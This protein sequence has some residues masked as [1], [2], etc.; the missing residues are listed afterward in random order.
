MIC[1]PDTNAFS[2]HLRGKS[3]RLS[4]RM[5][6]ALAEGQMRLSTVVLSELEYGAAKALLSG[7][8]RPERRVMQLREIVP[9]EEFSAAASRRYGR[10]R[11]MLE[12]SGQII[13]GMDML[14]AAHALALDALIV[15]G[16]IGE[17]SRV[18]GL[19]VENWE[20]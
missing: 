2:R 13:G 6:M 12:A 11:S 15:T 14:L 9:V 10:V 20:S 5:E 8:K 7:E 19:R 4:A 17:F 1:L 3:E 16:N 18:P